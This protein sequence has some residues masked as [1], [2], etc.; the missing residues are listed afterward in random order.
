MDRYRRNLDEHR[1]VGTI[2]RRAGSQCWIIWDVEPDNPHSYPEADVRY[3]VDSGRARIQH[4]TKETLIT[5][6]VK[7]EA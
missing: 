6:I 5:K 3:W 7:G 1:L 4:P 2:V